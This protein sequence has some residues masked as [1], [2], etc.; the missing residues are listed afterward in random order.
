MRAQ[1][2]KP[3]KPVIC[4]MGPT[5]CGKSKIAL[6]L[7]RKLNLEIVSVDS[8]LVYRGMD[9][10]TA[11]PNIEERRQV[12]HH[13]IDILD[14][15][16]RF[17]TGEFR[18]AALDLIQA[19]HERGKIPLLVGGTMLYFR[20]LLQGLALLP[21]ADSAIRAEIE[22]EAERIGWERMHGLLARV[23]PASAAKIHQNDPQRIQRALEVFR[24]SGRP[25]SE[26]CRNDIPQN[27]S[28][29]P[30]PVKI[31]PEDRHKLHDRIA[32]RFLA[33]LD[34][35]LIEEVENLLARGDL[36]P[37]YPSVRAVGYRQVWAYLH[38]ETTRETM[39][40]KAITATRQLAKRQLTWLR[41]ESGLFLFTM[42]CT[43]LAARILSDVEPLIHE[44]DQIQYQ[45]GDDFHVY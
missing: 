45:S 43:N 40:E 12:P 3:R 20:S 15:A 28:F 5:A 8:A 23:D 18:R 16:E 14:P 7:T 21:E 39:V 24:I 33:M 17:S 1:N 2:D 30:I 34:A 27:P 35:G 38:G 25:L 26:I 11:K 22:L 29:F 9:I 44:M 37:S 32:H 4:L 6:D 19:I 41:K 31:V 36:N 10:G 42:E 13:L